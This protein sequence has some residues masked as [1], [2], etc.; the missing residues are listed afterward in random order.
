MYLDQ[1]LR[2]VKLNILGYGNTA[3]KIRDYNNIFPAL[4]QGTHNSNS[5]DYKVDYNEIAQAIHDNE[6]SDDRTKAAGSLK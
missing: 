3:T 6:I 2:P 5:Y 4:Q 1:H